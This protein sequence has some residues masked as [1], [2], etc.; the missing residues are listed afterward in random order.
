MRRLL[1]CSLLALVSCGAAEAQEPPRQRT[2]HEVGLVKWVVVPETGERRDVWGARITA[3]LELPGGI[4]LDARCDVSAL[5]G[6]FEAA[7]PSTF[8]SGEAYAG[9][10]FPWRTGHLEVAPAAVFGRVVAFDGEDAP[11]R[12]SVWLAG[13][14]LGA[15]KAGGPWVYVGA[16]EHGPSGP[17]TRALLSAHIP[18]GS[19][20]G[21]V[22]Y[23]SGRGGFVRVGVGVR[24][25]GL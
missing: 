4:W 13:V 8:K 12:T 22:D 2:S 6:E 14:R 23:V 15:G 10:H 9:L 3:G 16:G 5:A 21:E 17:G 1:A 19:F 24:V 7:D 20:S 18:L 11:E 25:P